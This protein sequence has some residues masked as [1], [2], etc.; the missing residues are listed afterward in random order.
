MNVPL[1]GQIPLIT[2]IREAG[3]FGVPSALN[4]NIIEGKI[5]KELAQNVIECIKN[6][7]AISSKE[8]VD[9]EAIKSAYR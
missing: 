9:L 3:D 1:L 4:E 6:L 8:N 2:R 5:F 7:S